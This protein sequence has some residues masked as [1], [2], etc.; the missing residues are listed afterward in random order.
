MLPTMSQLINGG[1]L[2][3]PFLQCCR[4]VSTALVGA[5]DPEEKVSL[6]LIFS[7]CSTF[8]GG[9]GLRVATAWELHCCALRCG[10]CCSR[11]RRNCH[12][13]AVLAGGYLRDA[14]L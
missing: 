11:G 3:Q 7:E 13:T 12:F 6:P 4:Q 2:A 1:S 9:C 14:L 10:D 8:R 5:G